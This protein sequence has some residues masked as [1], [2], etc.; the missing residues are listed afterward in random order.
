MTLDIHFELIADP[1]DDLCEAVNF[2]LRTHNQ[3]S[4]PVHWKKRELDENQP[5]PL[6]IFAFDADKNVVGGLFATTQFSWLKIEIMATALEL[7]G[8]GVG[9]SLLTKAEEAGRERGC[10]YAFTDTMEYQA[11]EFY[12][13]AGYRVNGEFEDWD[14]HGHKKFFFVKDLVDK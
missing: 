12:K 7:R 8:Q 4:S 1:N 2:Q 3:T 5:Q 6:N 10:K 11:P 14:S 13:K 9:L